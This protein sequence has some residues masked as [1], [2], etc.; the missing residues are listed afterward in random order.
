MGSTASLREQ[1]GEDDV[2]CRVAGGL[3]ARGAACTT[4]GARARRLVVATATGREV[5]CCV[6]NNRGDVDALIRAALTGD[7]PHVRLLLRAQVASSDDLDFVLWQAAERGHLGIVR[8]LLEPDSR[9][10]LDNVFGGR[11]NHRAHLANLLS[12]LPLLGAA[13]KGHLEVVRL[14]L[15]HGAQTT[16]WRSLRRRGKVAS[17]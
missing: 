1:W 11:H 8:L 12:G 5:P 10:H 4:L 15:E 9:A 13:E 3:P 2:A 6:A 16:A 7:E 14:L 17:R